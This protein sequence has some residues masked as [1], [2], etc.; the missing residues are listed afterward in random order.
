MQRA[1]KGIDHVMVIVPDLD[2]AA[3]AYARLGFDVQPRGIH[4]GLGTANNLMI[5]NEDYI[6]LLGVLEAQPSNLRYKEIGEQGGALANVALGTDGADL[7]HQA[8]TKA[9]LNP[10]PIIAFDRGVDID[11]K[12]ER[13]AFRIVR[14]PH[15]A[16]PG[17]GLFVCDHLT[18]QF[19]YRPEWQRH[20]NTATG[21]SHI[22]IVAAD[23]AHHRAAAEK[24]FGADAI[25]TGDGEMIVAT[26]KAPFRYLTQARFA[27]RYPGHKPV[28]PGDHA[29]V[30]GI[31]VRDMRALKDCLARNEVR[32]DGTTDGRVL[33]PA[34]TAAN[35][36]IEFSA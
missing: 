35:V 36:L 29:A 9:G 12:Q 10:E 2:Q 27:Q 20:P 16:R 19:V 24:V 32:S 14:L 11:G 15:E 25:T 31:K 34:A 30:M 21:I 28:L 17:V 6:E 7:A 33:I 13:A 1:I 23:P 26:G 3:A 8:W 18:P 5:L 4:K 22:T